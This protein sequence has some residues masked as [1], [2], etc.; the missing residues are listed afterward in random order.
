MYSSLLDPLKKRLRDAREALSVMSTGIGSRARLVIFREKTVHLV[1]AKEDQTN[2]SQK[3]L[4]KV[5][6]HPTNSFK[7][8]LW[9][10]I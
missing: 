5:S 2:N 10:Q 3:S 1:V 7:Q 9:P 8:H 6:N 4:V